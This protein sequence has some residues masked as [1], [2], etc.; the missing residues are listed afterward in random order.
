MLFTNISLPDK[1]KTFK[2]YT[3]L[4]YV[5]IKYYKGDIYIYVV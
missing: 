5:T 2:S 4:L 1:L 3:A